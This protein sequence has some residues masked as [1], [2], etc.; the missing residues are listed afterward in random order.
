[1]LLALLREE[2]KR[3][4]SSEIQQQYY[5][6]GCDPSNDR[7]WIDVTDQIQYDLVREFGY[8]DE[9]VQLLRR[10][11]QLYKDD[12][13]FSNTQVYV[14]NNISQI[15]NLTEGMQAPDCSLVS[16]ESSA[17][18]V[19]LIPLCTLVR[20]GRPLVLLGGS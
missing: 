3:R 15:G 13:A 7:D 17:T 14:R 12:P 4:F 10:A 9:A 20:P 6:V 19:P 2:E 8:S 1:D 5:N 16:L 18:T 11:S